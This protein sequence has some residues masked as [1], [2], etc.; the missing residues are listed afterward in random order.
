MKEIQ[1]M[2]EIQENIHDNEILSYCVDFENENIIFNTIFGNK[3][4]TTIIFSN[5]MGHSF[6]N[7]IKN[8]IL[9]DIDEYSS[10]EYMEFITKDNNMTEIIDNSDIPWKYD[11]L[12]KIIEYIKKKNKKY[13]TINASYGLRGWILADEIKIIVKNKD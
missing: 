13:Y 3:E 2:E 5:V 10:E 4:K 8:S 1:D 9:N 7:E 6:S 12:E 11:T